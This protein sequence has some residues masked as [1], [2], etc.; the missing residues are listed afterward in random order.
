VIVQ[1][2]RAAMAHL[3]SPVFRAVLLKSVGSTILLLIAAWFGLNALFSAFA[4]PFI[5]GWFA[6]YPDLGGWIGLVSAIAAGIGLALV[7]ALLVGPVTALVAGFFLD[8]IAGLV[9]RTDFPDDPEGRPLP[10]LRSAVLSLK[11]VGTVLAGNLIA[12]ALLFVPFINVAAFFVVNGYLLGREYFEFAAMRHRPEADAGKMRRD[13][14]GTVFMAGLVIAAFM[15]V[16]VLN[17]LTPLFAG[18]MMVHLHR[19][20]ALA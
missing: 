13:N 6:S 16:P 12:L 11:F 15:A 10:A 8:D 14:A 18:A 1:S 19:R 5:G 2:A 7:L 3:F 4:V 17:L 20:L 9:E